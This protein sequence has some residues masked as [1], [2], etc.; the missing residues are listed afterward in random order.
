[1]LR[2]LEDFEIDEDGRFATHAGDTLVMFVEWA[3]DGAIRSE[4]IHQFGS[5][6][7]DESSAHFADQVAP[8]L[9]QQLKPVHFDEA[10]LRRHLEREY[11]PG[12][13]WNSSP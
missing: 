8:F 10:D 4:S 7:L 1:M 3:A 6:T 12:Q 5:A 2:A 13:D 11:R 9:A